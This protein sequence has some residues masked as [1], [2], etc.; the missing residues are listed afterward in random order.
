MVPLI[1]WLIVEFHVTNRVMH[2]F[3]MRQDIPPTVDID[4]GELHELGLLGFVGLDWTQF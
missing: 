3:E 2:Q 1:F 4:I